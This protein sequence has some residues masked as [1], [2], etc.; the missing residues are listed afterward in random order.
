MT[1]ETPSEAA[2]QPVTARS[3]ALAHGFRARHGVVLDLFELV[4]VALAVALAVRSFVF[5]PFDIPSKSMEATLQVGDYVFTEKFA[6]GYSRFSLPFGSSLPSF[7]RVF[8]HAP[9]RGDVAVFA[10]PSDPKVDFIKRVIGLPGDHIQLIGGVI[11]INDLPV[12]QERVEAFSETGQDGEPHRV[13]QYR[14]TL[15]N[16][17]SYLV[18]YRSADWPEDTTGVYTVP[19]GHYFMLGDNR[20]DSDDSRGIVGYVPFENLIGKAQFTILS[21]DEQKPAWWKFWTWPG[22][23]RAGRFFA[24][25]D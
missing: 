17:K 7:G 10:L 11:Y 25:I 18:L 4:V 8:A 23:F 22:A 12:P 9:N 6:Y 16:G 2:P 19:P 21:V 3:G 15:P 20:D 5:Q 13:A 24:P 1:D 14:E